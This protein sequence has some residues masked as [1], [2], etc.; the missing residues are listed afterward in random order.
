MKPSDALRANR[1]ELRELASRYGV[2]RPRI[3]GS[4]VN[5]TDTE[6]SDLDL[7]VD[8]SE[9]T[10]LLRLSA[11]QLEAERLLGVHVDVLTPK[12]LPASFRDRVLAEAVAL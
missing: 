4:V 1:A 8:P 10:T 6:D 12:S 7:L 2:V 5:G 3:F 9:S 11:M